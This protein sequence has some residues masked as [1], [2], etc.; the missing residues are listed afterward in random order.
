VLLAACSSAPAPSGFPAQPAQTL[1]S[2]TAALSVA[3][4]TS[5][6]PPTRGNLSV[7]YTITDA[8]TGKPASGL[9]LAVVPWMPVMGHGTSVTPSVSEAA[10]GTYVI[11][12]VDLFMPGVWVIR[13]T[14]SGASG[15][16]AAAAGVA[17]D[18]VGP[19]FEIP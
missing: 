1:G 9:S 6:Q 4:R 11:A 3:V 5:P 8:A 2:R 15:D 17:S 16:S 13:T 7:E 10:P 18:Y 14:I 12:N 19:T